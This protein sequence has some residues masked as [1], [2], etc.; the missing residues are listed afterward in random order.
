MKKS[1]KDRSA[2]SNG[3]LL[4]RFARKP[5]IAVPDSS[6]KVKLAGLKC[7]RG[8]T[9]RRASFAW[10]TRLLT[11]LRV[12]R[13]LTQPVDSSLSFLLPFNFQ[14]WLDTLRQTIGAPSAEAVIVW[15]PQSDR[16]RIYIHLLDANARPLAFV[17]LS[18][19]A[20]NDEHLRSEAQT[21]EKL[22]ALQLTSFHIPSLME[23]GKWNGHYYCVFEPI[24]TDA[25]PVQSSVEFIPPGLCQGICG[26]GADNWSPATNRT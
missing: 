21:I 4:F 13:L 24:P 11:R 3:Y 2:T 19:D 7:Y 10:M 9:I 20:L 22:K 5:V 26:S 12:D 14:D 16:G 1:S 15:P 25:K 17:K 18:L 23:I 6:Q 8:I